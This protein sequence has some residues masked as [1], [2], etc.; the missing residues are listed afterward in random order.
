MARAA[1][2]L[3]QGRAALSGS[4][5]R[6]LRRQCRCRSVALMWLNHAGTPLRTT[7]NNDKPWP[8][9]AAYAAGPTAAG[10]RLLLSTRKAGVTSATNSQKN[11]PFFQ[12]IIARRCRIRPPSHHWP[13]CSD[14]HGSRGRPSFRYDYKRHRGRPP[15]A[16][17]CR[18]RCSS[19]I[20]VPPRVFILAEVL[21]GVVQAGFDCAE[22]DVQR[23][24]DILQGHV[25]YEAHE[26]RLALLGGQ[27]PQG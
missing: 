10:P 8:G 25:V 19:L 7:W 15:A 14:M 20:K 24:S 5:A 1:A 16:C 6:R 3:T 23:I 18:A 22:W 9:F 27:Q 12:R 26:Q 11:K 4:G 21:E 17:P 13:S 2:P